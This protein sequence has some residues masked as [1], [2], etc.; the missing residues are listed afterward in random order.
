MSHRP[1][2]PRWAGDETG[3]LHQLVRDLEAQVLQRRRAEDDLR[4]SEARFRLLV[5]RA[6]EIVYRLRLWP[7]TGFEYISPTIAAITGHTPGEFYR[8]PGVARRLV[9]PDDRALVDD[10]GAAGDCSRP[11]ACR[12]VHRNGA[13][14]RIE[15]RSLPI[16][17]PGGRLMAVEGIARVPPA[18]ID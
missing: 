10:Y 11:L 14:V 7:E 16:Y 1:P 6:G 4:K 3:H 8:D 9:H 5:E 2:D 18:S 13:V 12:L 17:G 15:S